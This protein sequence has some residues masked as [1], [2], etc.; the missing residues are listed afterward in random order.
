MRLI[1]AAW[2]MAI[3]GAEP[4]A[5]ADA[6]AGGAIARKVCTS[7]HIVSSDQEVKPVY[8]N[9]LP[10]FAEIAARPGM[11]ED[12]LVKILKGTHRAHKPTAGMPFVGQ[13]EPEIHDVAHYVV[14]LRKSPPKPIP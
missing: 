6:A 9:D 8:G 13:T 3:L 10:S 1:V 4:V 14:S 12:A 7:C 11:T 2:A 5:A